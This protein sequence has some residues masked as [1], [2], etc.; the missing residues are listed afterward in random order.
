MKS[1]GF[2]VGLGLALLAAGSVRAENAKRRDGSS[3]QPTS[4]AEH[5]AA[6]P[7]SAS[8]HSGGSGS[9]DSGSSSSNNASGSSTTSTGRTTA[10]RRHPE[11]GSGRGRYY[12]GGYHRHG[13]YYGGGVWVDGCYGCGVY[14]VY[15]WY[16]PRY[17]YQYRYYDD[18]PALRVI[19]DP[20]KTRVYVDRYYA[21]VA[22]DF[23]G[24]FQRLYV[25][26]G[27]HTITLKLEGYRSHSFLIYGMPGRSV[28]LHWNMVRGTGE[29]EPENLAGEAPPDAGPVAVPD[30]EG[31]DEHGED[32]PPPGYDPDGAYD[33]H[34]NAP[35]EDQ[36]R[37]SMGMLSLDVHPRDAAVY[38]DGT[39]SP[40]ALRDDVKL[41]VGTHKIQVVR[42]GY[43]NF[44][45]EV[46]IRSGKTADLDVR[47]EK[48]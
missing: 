7:P 3:S 17:R 1:G 37:D 32:A 6:P 14:D 24:I 46:E 41:P 35:R 48:S 33:P 18:S 26:P 36:P 38:I 34:H 20:E 15:P 5:H 21:G 28:K 27:R 45:R 4:G 2:W 13:G 47:L 16:Y 11:A 31:D 42:P 12:G 9:S 29:D 44:E 23:D 19:V 30:D 40:Q 25:S 43:R 39:L 8:S 10:E 22:D